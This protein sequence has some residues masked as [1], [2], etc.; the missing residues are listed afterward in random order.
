MAQEV[1]LAANTN[2]FIGTWKLNLAKSKF[3]PGP[4]V[5]SRTEKS[6]PAGDAVKTSVEQVDANGNY[7]TVVETAKFDGKDYPRVAT[8][9]LAASGG[10]TLALKRIDAY[11]VE[12][13]I[14]K[15][16]EVVT[17]I[18]QVVSKDGKTKTATYLKGTNT[19]GQA[20]HNVLV[21]DSQ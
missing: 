20:V 15:H 10:D 6:E 5:R 12:A 7:A 8:G 16:G 18:R 19:Q 14:K 11:T 2:P 9:G 1:P 17:V 21:F 13:T 3:D 4:P